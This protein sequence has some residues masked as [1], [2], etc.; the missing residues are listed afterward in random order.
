MSVRHA[1]PTG[2]GGCQV[3]IKQHARSSSSSCIFGCDTETQSH[4]VSAAEGPG[5][6]GAGPHGLS[7]TPPHPTPPAI[8]RGRASHQPPLPV[9]RGAPLLTSHAGNPGCVSTQS[10]ASG[11]PREPVV[12]ATW[13]SSREHAVPH[14]VGGSLHP[15]KLQGPASPGV[16]PPSTA[17]PPAPHDPHGQPS[18]G[19]GGSNVP[20]ISVWKETGISFPREEQ[21]TLTSRARHRQGT[22]VQSQGLRAIRV[23]P[24]PQQRQCPWPPA[25]QRPHHQGTGRVCLPGLS[26][27]MQT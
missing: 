21:W 11:S 5:R 20:V 2:H 17:S 13:S 22:R 23:P 6:P 25:W 15:A 3:L 26:V 14:E 16:R 9:R 7:P 19:P 24:A 1:C 18:P 12:S 10:E 4:C 27:Q 8:C